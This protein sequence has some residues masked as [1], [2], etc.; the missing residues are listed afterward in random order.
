M[1]KFKEIKYQKIFEGYNITEIFKYVF[2]DDPL[3]YKR[4]NYNTF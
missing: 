3:E 2:S 1:H 4:Q